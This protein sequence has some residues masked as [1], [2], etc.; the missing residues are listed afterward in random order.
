MSGSL[1]EPRVC[2]FDLDGTLV[3]SLRD[4]AESLNSCLDLLGLPT[5]LVDSYR[6]MVGEGIPKLC[7]RAVGASHPHLVQRLGE[8]VTDL[9]LAEGDATVSVGG[10]ES[11]T[12]AVSAE[13]PTL[14]AR[15]WHSAWML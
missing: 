1:P 3:N 8:L 13:R 5:H 14:P 6:Y 9:Y 7:Q 15:L 4:I 10:V 11:T 12:N 2:I